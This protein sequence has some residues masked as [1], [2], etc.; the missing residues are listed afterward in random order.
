MG[1]SQTLCFSRS[2]HSPLGHRG[3]TSLPSQALPPGPYP[4]ISPLGSPGGGIEAIRAPFGR[5]EG[6]LPT[7]VPH[8]TSQHTGVIYEKR[9]LKHVREKHA[10]EKIICVNKV[11]L[12]ESG[13]PHA[14]KV[15]KIRKKLAY[16]SLLNHGTHVREV[17]YLCILQ[18]SF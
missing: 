7:P 8:Q 1:P 6:T 12:R 2:L 16:Q 18:V 4:N 17:K 14:G 3:V 10:G 9:L 5:L 11:L 13:R 15:I